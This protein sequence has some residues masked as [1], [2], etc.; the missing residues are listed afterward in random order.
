MYDFGSTKVVCDGGSI[1][2]L[3]ETFTKVLIALVTLPIEDMAL[4][5]RLGCLQL[6]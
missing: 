3:Q 1:E 4:M 5:Q 6:L 2:N